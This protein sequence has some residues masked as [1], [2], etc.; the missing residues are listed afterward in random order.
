MKRLVLPLFL[1]LCLFSQEVDEKQRVKNARELGKGGS[2]NITQLTPLLSDTSYEVRGE[3][4]RSIVRIGTQ[5]SLDPLIQATRDNDPEVQLRAT[6][7]IV[8]FYLPGYIGSSNVARLS[9]AIKSR[10]QKENT[11]VIEPFVS[12]RPEAVTA[13]AA[14]VGGGAGMDVRANAARAVGILRGRSAVPE[15]VRAL[16][17]KDGAL[18]FES[19]IALQKI[20][21]PS[22]A[23]QISFLLRDLEERVQLAAIETT[24]LLRNRGAV[25][26]LHKVFDSGRNDRVRRSALTAIAMIADSESRPYF[27]RGLTD[28]ND[29]VR[30][31]AAEGIARLKDKSL[32]SAVQQVFE[33]ESKMAPR[34]AAAFALVSLGRTEQSQDSPFIYLVN[35]LNSKSYSGVARPYLNELARQPEVRA[36]LQQYAAQGTREEKI[37]VGQVLSVSGD[38]DSLAVLETLT[39]DP[40]AQVAQES[41]RSLR[42]LRARIN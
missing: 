9:T 41:L 33:N 34:L 4:V 13:L 24:G 21:D 17:S 7:G 14:L 28:K 29:G 36:S 38:K 15:L 31:A 11:D 6:D 42:N 22:V 35:A 25:A 12:V 3:A 40:D 19:L 27:E 18:I 30:A 26:D 1:T 16:H 2:E 20:Q 10:F 8:N 39:K 32:L 23:P 5:Y 37:G